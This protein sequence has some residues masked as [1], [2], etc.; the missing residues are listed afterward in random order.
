M[1]GG[2]PWGRRLDLGERAAVLSIGGLADDDLAAVGVGRLA[3]ILGVPR[4]RAGKLLDRLIELRLVTEDTRAPGGEAVY[5][6]DLPA[7]A[8]GYGA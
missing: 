8:G 1:R 2:D 5:R 4:Y 6:L 7:E 3:R